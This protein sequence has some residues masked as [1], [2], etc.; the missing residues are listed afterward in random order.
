MS[1]AFVKDIDLE[2]KGSLMGLIVNYKNLLNKNYYLMLKD[3]IKFYNFGLK[4]K[5]FNN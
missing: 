4:Y 2:Y 3:I 1:L 5:K